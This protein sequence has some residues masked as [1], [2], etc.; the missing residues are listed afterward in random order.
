MPI[1]GYEEIITLYAINPP[2]PSTPSHGMRY[3]RKRT[4]ISALDPSLASLQSPTPLSSV[5][6][7]SADNSSSE[8]Q[9][10]LSSL[11]VSSPVQS[12]AVSRRHSM[13]LSPAPS[14]IDIIALLSD[15][16]AASIAREERL[17]A[18]SKAREDR[19]ND[20]FTANLAV[21]GL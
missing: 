2:P 21:S 6:S 5:L 8:S 17:I 19:L 9:L 11:S 1:P 12:T 7:L 4:I 10:T 15:E 3:N 18:E 16:R 13:E 20:R 14:N